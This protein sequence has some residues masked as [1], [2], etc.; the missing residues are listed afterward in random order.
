MSR[1]EW[2]ARLFFMLLSGLALVLSVVSVPGTA[3]AGD[4]QV[5]AVIVHPDNTIQSLDP[6]QIAYLFLR[7]AK[8]FPGGV[9]AKP[10]LLPEDSP[11]RTRFEHD[12]LRKEPLQI[13]AYWARLVFTGRGKPPKSMPSV[14]DVK[15]Y[16]ASEP[17]AIS[18]IP[19]TEV[20][21]SVKVVYRLR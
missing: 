13:R 16:V 10:V 5:I 4:R 20:D 8:A 21:A 1:S 12:I 19:D 9:M 2:P 18:Y 14:V 3:M 15:R 6:D 7:K 11:A 17:A